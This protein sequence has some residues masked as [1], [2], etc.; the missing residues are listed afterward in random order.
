MKPVAAEPVMAR[1]QQRFLGVFMALVVT[2]DIGIRV[3]KHYWRAYDPFDKT[4][5]VFVLVLLL[6]LP[7]G[8][9]RMEK[10]GQ[11]LELWYVYLVVLLVA[12]LF[13]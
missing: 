13:H 11:K 7:W 5:A 1:W 6:M 9:I 12:T 4:F 3:A 2:A 8:V 10:R